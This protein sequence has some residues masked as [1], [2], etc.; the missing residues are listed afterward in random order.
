MLRGLVVSV[1]V[2]GLWGCGDESEVAELTTYV[3][4]IQKFHPYNVK[5]QFYLANLGDPAFGLKEQDVIDARQLL[6]DYAAAVNGVG[7]P[8]ENTLRHSHGLY[9]RS[10]VDA[11]RLAQ[12]RTGDLKRQGHSVAIGFRNLRRDIADR[13]YPSLEVLLDRKELDYEGDY[14]LKWPFPEK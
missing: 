4:A 13:L 7:E 1:L 12:D 2:L 14:A 6:E 8:D 5:V 10:F 9:K 3:K 11:R